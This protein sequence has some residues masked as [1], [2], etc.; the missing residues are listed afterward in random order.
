VPGGG[1]G[2]GRRHRCRA[3]AP[4]MAFRGHRPKLFM[5]CTAGVA[6]ALCTY[7]ATVAYDGTAYKGFQLQITPDE[8]RVT[9]QGEI[10]ACLSKMF[11]ADRQALKVQG[12]GRTDSGVHAR[13]QVC[14]PGT[15]QTL[16]R[17]SH[18]RRA[19]DIVVSCVPGSLPVWSVRQA[20]WLQPR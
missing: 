2:A 10:E 18:W 5:S 16:P 4:C 17:H 8:K 7:K 19:S 20:V 15:P 9:I 1:T 14:A 12:A 6:K 3:E 11:V 13:G